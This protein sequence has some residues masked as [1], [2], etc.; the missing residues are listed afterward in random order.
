MLLPDHDYWILFG[1]GRHNTAFARRLTGLEGPAFAGVGD[2][3][4]QA[5][6]GL[7]SQDPEHVLAF[8]I[9]GEPLTAVAV[10][11]P[12]IVRA[13]SLRMS[14]SPNPSR[15]TTVVRWSGARGALQVL[16][17]LERHFERKGER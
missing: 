1:T 2:L 14:A 10:E 17:A 7:W 13:G 16:D 8:K 12:G 4:V 3:W 9:I 11:D 15:G 5:V 6:G